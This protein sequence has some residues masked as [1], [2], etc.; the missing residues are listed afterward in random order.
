MTKARHV[1][2]RQRLRPRFDRLKQ[3]AAGNFAVTVLGVL[4]IGAIAYARLA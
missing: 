2:R 1:Y 4:A 3:R